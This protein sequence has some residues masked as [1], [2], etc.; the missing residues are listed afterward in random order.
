MSVL[1]DNLNEGQEEAVTSTEG[2]LLILAG[3][4]S[5]K[6]KTLTHRVAY[7][8]RERNIRPEHILAVTFTNKA[9][10]EMR[11]RIER[12]LDN[13]FAGE[14]SDRYHLRH[15]S[16]IIG[17]FHS[18]CVRILRRDIPRIGYLANFTILDSIDQRSLVRRIVKD[19]SLDPEKFKP[20]A[21]LA[22]ISSAKNNLVNAEE[23]ARTAEGYFEERVSQVYKAY[24]ARLMESQSLDFDDLLL[25]VID[26]FTTCPDVLLR[27]QSTFRYVLVDEY[28][29]TNKLQYMILQMLAR[30][31]RNICAVGDDWQSIY[32]F[33]G[34]DI[35]NILEFERDYPEA[36]IVRL[37][38]NYRSSQNI[39]DAAYGVISHNIDRKDKELWTEKGAGHLIT[40]YEAQDEV[41]EAEFVAQESFELREKGVTWSDM[42][43][44]YRTNAQSRA[45]EEVFLRLDIPYRIVGGV[46][47][48]ERKEIKD[49]LA[50][51]RLLRNPNDQVSLERAANEPKRGIGDRTLDSW[52]RYARE[53]GKD[54]LAAGIDAG[55]VPMGL[56]AGKAACVRDFSQRMIALRD[57]MH[58]MTVSAFIEEVY[59][60]TGFKQTLLSERTA[61]AK[62]R[63][64]NIEELFSVATRYAGEDLTSEMDRFLE[65]VA[66]ASDVDSIDRG[67]Q[68]IHLMTI[69]SAKGLEFPC[70]FIV[71]LEEGILP[72]S[73]SYLSAA[74]LEEER[75]LL[76]VGVT[77][78]KDKVY[79]LFTRQRLLFGLSQMNPPSRFL[80]E[81]PNNLLDER[82]A[83]DYDAEYIPFVDRRKR[84]KRYDLGEAKGSL[85][86][87]IT[88]KEA[89][90]P[91]LSFS[92]GEKVRHGSFGDGIV[93]SHNE[94]VIVVLFGKA[95][96]KKLASEYAGLKKIG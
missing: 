38:Q 73:R 26:L 14:E 43:V 86:A 89:K 31:H 93:I 82:R 30:E 41:G 46:R 19:M 24:E 7:L 5:G 18:V 20:Q 90:K 28:Q 77:R 11:E 76:Y 49:I 71:G 95:G 60:K 92:D 39:L 6:T 68:A 79:L 4:G 13:G 8:I 58:D 64:E 15:S 88:K 34:A 32:G 22:A 45:L 42:A 62:S 54:F 63:M 21:F 35:R 36:K 37:E 55:T 53:S 57:E 52:I 84:A 40:S 85:R 44:L 91:T 10:G 2:P 87:E 81:I 61:E 29:D 94:K 23:Y 69:H 48:Y 9:A 27:Y 3:A 25:R 83:P 56:N 78:A 16:P 66:L 74:D 80:A 70:V 96:L 50:Y 65:E 17:T 1:L 59:E 72:H 67:S 33:R 12:L 75:R 51:L 47:F